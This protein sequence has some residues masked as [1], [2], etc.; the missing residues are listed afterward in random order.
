MV[1]FARGNAGDGDKQMARKAYQTY[2]ELAPS[3]AGAVHARRQLEKVQAGERENEW[4]AVWNRI[5]ICT[6]ASLSS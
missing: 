6:E 2:L 5:P 1:A 3:A 4:R